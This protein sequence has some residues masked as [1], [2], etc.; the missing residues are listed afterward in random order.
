M[1]KTNKTN[2]SVFSWLSEFV[3]GR[4]GEYL[5]SVIT[6]LIGVACSLIPYFIII[7]II[8]ALINGTAELSYYLT[9][10]Y[11]WQAY[12]FY[13][14]YCTAY[15]LPF[16]T[17]QHVLAKVRIMLLDK[18]AT[19]P[20]GTVLDRSSGSYKNIIVEVWILLKP[21]LHIFCPK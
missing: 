21:R 14:I 4:R 13:A 5:I 15:Q 18:L 3:K 20:L 16:P 12:G 19:L 6:A 17:T 11:G 7:K 9:P 8:T 2:R 1:N 10:A